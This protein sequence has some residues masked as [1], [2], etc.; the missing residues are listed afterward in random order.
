A[1]RP[2]DL[3]GVDAAAREQARGIV[4]QLEGE[5]RRRDR[6][7]GDE[8][9]LQRQR[10]AGEELLAR[11]AVRAQQ[12]NA[13]DPRLAAS[14][15]AQPRVALRRAQPVVLCQRVARVPVERDAA[16]SQED[17]PLAETLDRRGVV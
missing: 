6:G 11:L 9:Q 7:R 10:L 14:P 3:R 1:V 16:L 2:A 15:F 5:T 17:R 4:A 13:R 8:R 12:L